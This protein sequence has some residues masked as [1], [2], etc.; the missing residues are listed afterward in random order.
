MI[1]K[2]D[3]QQEAKNYVRVGLRG[4]LGLIRVDT[5]RMVHNVGF[6]VERLIYKLKRA[7][8]CYRRYRKLVRCRL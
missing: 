3:N 8:I 6:L 5:F 7:F 2:T 1:P 4:M